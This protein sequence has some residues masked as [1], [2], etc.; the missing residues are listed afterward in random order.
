MACDGQ[1]ICHDM[2][3]DHA[4]VKI[5]AT[6]RGIVGCAG[7]AENALA[8]KAW[9][10][11]GERPKIKKA[12]EALILARDGSITYHCENDLDGV[13]AE[14]P[15]AIGSGMSYAIAAMDAGAT[16]ERA[17]EIAAHRC[18]GIGGK[19]TVLHLEGA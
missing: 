18:P 5:W 7:A 11:G 4:A 3:V 12:F 10:D 13:S 8:F 2:I 14:A 17:V 19:I 6:P 15:T 9:L 16:P 1:V